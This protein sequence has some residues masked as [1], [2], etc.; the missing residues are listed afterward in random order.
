LFT[1]HHYLLMTINHDQSL[2]ITI[3]ITINII[4]ITTQNDQKMPQIAHVGGE[5]LPTMGSTVRGD[6]AGGFV[7]TLAGR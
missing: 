1:I 2:F 3:K 6:A 7:E 4:L 5:P